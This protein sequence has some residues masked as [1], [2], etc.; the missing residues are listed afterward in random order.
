V[1]SPYGAELEA[2]IRAA[3]AAGVS[4]IVSACP[5]ISDSTSTAYALSRSAHS[6]SLPGYAESTTRPP[7]RARE[8]L[9]H[10]L[11]TASAARNVSVIDGAFNADNLRRQVRKSCCGILYSADVMLL[12][13]AIRE[14]L[15]PI[16]RALAATSREVA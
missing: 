4:R 13:C 12:A 7:A 9:Q 14:Q 16:R 8:E 10:A 1:L 6:T 11:R 5:L 3:Y 2:R 15:E